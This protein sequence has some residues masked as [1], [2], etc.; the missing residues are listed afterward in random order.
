[1]RRGI[2][3]IVGLGIVTALFLA[4]MSVFYLQQIPTK[5]DLERLAEDLRHEHGLYLSAAARLDV[6]LLQ[7]QED[8]GITGLRISCALRPDIRQRPEMVRVY[9]TR[10]ADSILDHPEWRGRISHVTAIH[11]VPPEL[12]VTRRPG[13]EAR[14]KRSAP[15]SEAPEAPEAPAEAPPTP[16]K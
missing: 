14:E 4:I 6:T 1:V 2:T 5:A 15:A 9:L 12:S 8:R 16:P 11:A 7:P 10:M 3:T 13:D